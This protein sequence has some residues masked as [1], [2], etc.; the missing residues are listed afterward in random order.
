MQYYDVKFEIS[1]TMDNMKT[2]VL[3]MDEF[4]IFSQSLKQLQKQRGDLG[5]VLKQ[6]N[7]EQIQQLKEIMQSKRMHVI[8]SQ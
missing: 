3:E 1:V 4:D 5:D 2:P 6:M 8:E 7:N